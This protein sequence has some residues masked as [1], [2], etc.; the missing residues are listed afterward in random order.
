M[1]IVEKIRE[2]GLDPIVPLPICAEAAG[3]SQ[4]TLKAM[5]ARGEMEIIRVSE[6]RCGIRRSVLDA[7]LESR[8]S[9]VEPIARP[10]PRK[11]LGEGIKRMR[12]EHEGGPLPP[13]AAGGEGAV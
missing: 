2:L 12:R 4:Q 8:K 1:S 7:F 10:A 13:N 11:A 3:L 6:R 9:A 5:A